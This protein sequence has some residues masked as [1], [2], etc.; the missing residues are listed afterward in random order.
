MDPG[1]VVVAREEIEQRPWVVDLDG[2]DH[3]RQ[4]CRDGRSVE[5]GVAHG[6]NGTRGTVMR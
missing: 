2:P 1:H 3:E 4:C 6:N 5:T